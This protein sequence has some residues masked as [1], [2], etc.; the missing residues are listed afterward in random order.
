MKRVRTVVKIGDEN[1]ANFVKFKKIGGGSL[2]LRG[3]IIK[4]NEV[5]E[6]DPEIIPKAFMNTLIPLEGNIKKKMDVEEEDVD[7]GYALHHRGGPWWDVVDKQG[8]P[9]NEKAMR[10]KDAENLLK[11]L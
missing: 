8:K 10:I 9:I 1:S 4:P 5:F 3:R 2:L 11:N 7:L 6:A